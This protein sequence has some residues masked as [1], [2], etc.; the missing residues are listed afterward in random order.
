MPKPL[1][2]IF[3][4]FANLFFPHICEACGTDVLSNDTLLCA[5]CY[6]KLPA[7][8]FIEHAGN[9][10]EQKFY[11][12][13]NIAAAGAAYYFTKDGMLQFLIKQLKYHGNKDIGFYLGRQLGNLLLKTDRF[14]NVDVIIPLP[15]N[16]RKE[17]KRGYNQA[18]VI[19]DG[20][21]SLW[22]KP[23]NT[24][25]VER[26]IFTET[27]THKDRISRWQSMRNVFTVTNSSA[28][29]GKNILLVDDIVT[30]GA[31]LEA[32]GEKILEVPGTKLFIATVA[33]TI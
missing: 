2:D 10:V 12:Q 26:K 14:N 23:V 31:T 18:A 24:T 20:I 6:E 17:K 27:Q 33:Y 32:C 30:T 25:A 3:N 15:L 19:A 16:P 11:G 13:L 7:T 29:E 21:N 1:K 8:N 28:L 9:L 22:Q 4:N 5:G